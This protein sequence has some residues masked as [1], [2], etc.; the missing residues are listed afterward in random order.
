MGTPSILPIP[1][2]PAQRVSEKF[3]H[4]ATGL[5]LALAQR[6][7]TYDWLSASVATSEG[8]Y[9]AAAAKA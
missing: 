2:H 9:L 4:V 3:P 1:T 8:A 5:F 6:E 7:S